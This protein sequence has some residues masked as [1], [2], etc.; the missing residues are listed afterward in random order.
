MV[1]LMIALVIV[2][3]VLLAAFSS[4]TALQRGF[5]YTTAWSEGRANQTRL[6]D[7]LAVDLRNATKIAPFPSPSPSFLPITL[8]IPKRYTAYR[9]TGAAAGEPGTTGSPTPVPTPST[10][11]SR[12]GSNIKYTDVNK[13]IIEA[14]TIDVYY[15]LS[16]D[17]TK[18]TRTVTRIGGSVS[19][20]GASR[21][22]A[23]FPND[24]PTVRFPNAKGPTVKFSS[25]SPTSIITS[26]TNTQDPDYLDPDRTTKATLED[27][28]FLRQLSTQLSTQ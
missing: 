7:S 8:T 17:K 11:I 5:G 19:S 3:F 4:S 28:V 24:S 1:E 12:T 27:T 18:I 14:S 22:V 21:D 6:L 2:G 25:N 20:A 23:T 13:Q 10:I 15:A 9:S 16:A 26:I